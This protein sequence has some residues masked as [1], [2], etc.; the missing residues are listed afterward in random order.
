MKNPNP[1]F[2]ERT[3]E[4][5]VDLSGREGYDEGYNS[6][7]VDVPSREAQPNDDQEWI[8][9]ESFATEAEAIKFAQETYGSDERGFVCL[10]SPTPAQKYEAQGAHD[11]LAKALKRLLEAF[12]VDSHRVP[13]MPI[14]TSVETNGEA[15]REAYAALAEVQR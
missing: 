13:N 2:Y 3:N 6:F 4:S 10:V 1:E 9:V 5:P 14:I 12:L 8:N 11:K 15:I 7:H